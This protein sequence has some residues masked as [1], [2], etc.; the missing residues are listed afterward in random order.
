MFISYQRNDA[1]KCF[2]VYNFI[3]PVQNN[4]LVENRLPKLISGEIDV[5]KL[6]IAVD[7]LQ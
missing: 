2:S 3:C 5:E 6:D 7:E 1:E 4:N